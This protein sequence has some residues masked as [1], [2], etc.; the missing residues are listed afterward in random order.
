MLTHGKS[1]RFENDKLP[2]AVKKA[3]A[4]EVEYLAAQG[5]AKAYTGF[6]RKG[7]IKE[8]IGSYSYESGDQT[9]ITV[10]GLPVSQLTIAYLDAEGLRCAMI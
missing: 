1:A 5:S 4:A 10:G 2:E 3:V 9:G 8:S 7:V 6:P